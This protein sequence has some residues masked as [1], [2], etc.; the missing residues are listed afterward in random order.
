[1]V[2]HY[3][4]R[5]SCGAWEVLVLAE[6]DG[7]IA[8]ART[9]WLSFLFVAP[10]FRGRR[11]GKC[12]IDRTCDCAKENGYRQVFFYTD[13]VGLY[14]KLEFTFLESKE[15]NWGDMSRIYVRPL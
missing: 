13:H 7:I 3:T 14:E 15:D 11:L 2:W 4:S 8:P 6:K 12:L 10:E 1:M 9:P 5:R